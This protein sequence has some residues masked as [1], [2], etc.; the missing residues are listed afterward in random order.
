MRFWFPGSDRTVRV[1][2][3]CLAGLWAVY[4]RI[5]W[6]VFRPLGCSSGPGEVSVLIPHLE[7][8]K[9]LGW[10]LDVLFAGSARVGLS[11]AVLHFASGGLGALRHVFI[12]PCVHL[13]FYFVVSLTAGMVSA[14][15]VGRLTGASLFAL[16]RHPL[17]PPA[18]RLFALPCSER[19]LLPLVC[20]WLCLRRSWGA[21]GGLQCSGFYHL[22]CVSSTSCC[23]VIRGMVPPL[24]GS[25]N[26]SFTPRHSLASM[27]RATAAD[28]ALI[29]RL[30]GSALFPWAV[31]SCDHTCVFF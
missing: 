24:L 3:W 10:L 26:V 6:S 2:W 7:A 16:C 9:G 30:W 22:G 14:S 28:S 25:V 12:W 21:S 20:P 31:L 27:C 5:L 23:R 18:Q 4:G 29:W 1:L 13:R 15:W 17:A 11:C 8:S 19:I